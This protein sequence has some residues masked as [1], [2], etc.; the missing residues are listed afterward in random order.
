MVN[1]T[2]S[3]FFDLQYN[4]NT[5]AVSKLRSDICS[6]FSDMGIRTAEENGNIDAFTDFGHIK[7]LNLCI[8]DNT[9]SCTV[10][11][12]NEIESIPNMIIQKLRIEAEYSVFFEKLNRIAKDLLA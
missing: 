10:F 3:S 4:D 5:Q 7:L 9:V 1:E 12:Y 2:V 6:H 8:A 11:R